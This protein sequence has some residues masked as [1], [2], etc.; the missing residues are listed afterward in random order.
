VTDNDE[1]PDVDV[2]AYRDTNLRL[3]RRIRSS[4]GGARDATAAK[5]DR[6]LDHQG[7]RASVAICLLFPIFYGFLA[8]HLGQDIGFDTLNYHFFDP[9]W[10]LHDHFFDIA[11]ALWQTYLDPVFNIPTYLLQSTLSARRASFIIAGFQG[12]AYIPLYIIGKQVTSRRSI[13]FGLAALGMLSA[14]AWSEIGTS[15]GDN[16]VAIFFLSST[17]LV[18]RTA[19]VERRY[20]R[21]TVIFAGAVGGVAAGLKLTEVPIAIG[22]LVAIPTLRVASLSRVA[23]TLRYAA[24]LIAGFV[25][26]YGYWGY[27]LATRYGNPVLPFFNNIFHSKFAPL[28]AN[29]DG[30]STAKNLLEWLFYPLLWAFN[31]HLVSVISFRELSLPIC[32]LLL[33]IAL[34]TRVYSYARRR[35]WIPMFSTQLERFLVVGTSASV[36]IW[37][38][39]IG[40]YRYIT[41]IEMLAFVLL[42][43][44]TGSVL[45][46]IFAV[47]FPT[48]LLNCSV[49]VLCAVCAL[50]ERPANWGR[51]PF[52]G[53]FFTVSVPRQFR[54]SGVTLLMLTDNP[55][56]Y[57]VPFLPADTDVIRIQSDPPT[58]YVNT[59]IRNRLAKASAIYITW[60]EVRL[61]PFLAENSSAWSQY[62]MAVVNGSCSVFSTFMGST[63]K[64]IHF[65][66]VSPTD[67]H[68][69]VVHRPN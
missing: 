33:W 16:F 64:W 2:F 6:E 52:A 3:G 32:E 9:Y 59:L 65:C 29:L 51:S 35:V 25:V 20:S 53:R 4:I 54:R 48:R 55:Y 57:I 50:T 47:P 19:G 39:V 36:L 45:R 68:A 27:E 42:W 56:T 66:Q 37:A 34:G 58:P 17:A 43:V 5:S 11:P 21:W 63:R 30:Q 23:S 24:G 12:L 60:T 67:S 15:F 61:Q 26:T 44:L 13:A 8:L 10:V 31:S 1:E 28:T 41:S 14:V 69:S 38:H 18:G 22:F 62:G 40:L 7:R 49:A 46:G